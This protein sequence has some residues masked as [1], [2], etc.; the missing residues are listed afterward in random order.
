MRPALVALAAAALAAGCSKASD[1]GGASAPAADQPAEPAEPAEPAAEPA[2]P[3][4]RHQVLPDA[5]AALEH[6]LAGRAPR[7]IGFGEYHQ[8]AA[9]A[10]VPSAI[11]RF[12]AE[13]IDALAPHTSDLVVET[14]GIDGACGEPEATV[15]RQVAADTERPAETASEVVLLAERA[16]ALGIAPHALTVSCDD[17]QALLSGGEVDYEVLLALVTRELGATAGKVLAHRGDGDGRRRTVAVYGGAL[18]NDLYPY[19]STAEWSYVPALAALVGD[20][21]VEVDLYVPEIIEGNALLAKERWYPLFVDLAGPDRV[22]L[23]ERAPRSYILILPRSR[24]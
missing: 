18:H 4:L 17:Y 9:T 12:T 22:V 10:D 1:S 13:M 15:T 7:V 2:E 14:W 6:I 3:A 16:R 24:G 5:A 21:Y 20:D 8:T 11:G 19:E 23:I